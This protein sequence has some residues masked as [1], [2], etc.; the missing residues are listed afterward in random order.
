MPFQLFRP[1]KADLE[2][3][4]AFPSQMARRTGA[5]TFSPLKNP[6]RGR[7]SS[8]CRVPELSYIRAR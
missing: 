3:L 5:A 4:L 6:S 7:G 2:L 1:W 8:I